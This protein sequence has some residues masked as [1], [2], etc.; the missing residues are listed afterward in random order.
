MFVY[1]RAKSLPAEVGWRSDELLT[2]ISAANSL[3]PV[4]VLLSYQQG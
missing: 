4:S 2:E 3:A 1:L